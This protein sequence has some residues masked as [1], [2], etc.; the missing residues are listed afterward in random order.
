MNKLVCTLVTAS[1]L[2]GGSAF[3]QD[4]SA[5]GKQ[6]L[7]DNQ[8]DGVTAGSAI[9]IGD[10]SATSSNTG[11]V[12]LSGGALSG[13][14]GV[15]IV[16]SSNSLVA[17]GVNVY[18]NSLTNQV[19]GKGA[20][21]TQANGLTQTQGTNASAQLE[22]EAADVNDNILAEAEA[23][24]AATNIAAGD[25]KINSSSSYNVDLSGTAGENA[26]G[27]N[28][29]NAAGG[30]VANGVNLT[31]SS[32]VNAVPVLTQ[33]NA[34]EQADLTKGSAI[35]VGEASV[36]SSN[37]GS[38]SLSGAALNGASG[39]N[40]VNSA[41]SAV[42]NGVNIYNS[43]LTTQAS[44]GGAPVT[45]A[46]VLTQN[47]KTNAKVQIAAAAPIDDA[48]DVIAL[49]AQAKATN[50]AVADAKTNSSSNYNVDLAGTAEQNA[51]ALNIVNSAGGMVSNGINIAHSVNMNAVP[52][53]TQVNLISQAR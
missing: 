31:E 15:N 30:L 20:V 51:S 53:L 21:V 33:V 9:A 49:A 35:A 34:I 29:V 19:G 4:K 1:V 46:N 13:A 36:T 27:I 7:R 24:A 44:N 26:T 5:S 2:V 48:G 39:V 16:T 50:I 12:N 23:A 52:A 18:D 8:M 47:E 25:A 10:A 38:V 17:N 41:D 40:I 14:T 3:A 43:S 11:S 32:N 28:I 42:A 45:Q 37:S 22:L 6:S